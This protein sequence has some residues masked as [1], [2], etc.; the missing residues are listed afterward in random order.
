V[1]VC[2]PKENAVIMAYVELVDAGFA[3]KMIYVIK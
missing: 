1:R 3:E 2:V